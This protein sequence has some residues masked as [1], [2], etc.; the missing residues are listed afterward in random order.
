[1]TTPT[2]HSVRP[3]PG[4]P[5][6]AEVTRSHD[7]L[8]ITD[9]LTDGALAR[10]C[11]EL[12]NTYAC[13]IRLR[14]AR[15]RVIQPSP[16]AVGWSVVERDP[17]PVDLAFPIE[18]GG[19]SIG[20]LT[21][22][23]RAPDQ[24]AAP[25]DPVPVVELLARTASEFCEQELRVRNRA[26]ELGALERLTAMLVGVVDSDAVINTA[27]DSALDVLALDAGS[28]VVFRRDADGIACDESE[29][30]LV[31]RA[32][33]RLSDDW[34]ESPL[35]LS[36]DRLFDRLALQG[37]VVVSEDLLT[38][39][40]VLMPERVADEGL[41]SCIHA[42]L[43][44]AGRPIG[45]MRLYA[46]S[47][48]RFT[49]SDQRL[50]RALAEH[51][52]AAVERARLHRV[53]EREER[54]RQQLRVAGEIQRRTLPSTLPRLPGVELAARWVPTF[55]IGGDFY[56][57][58]TIDDRLALAVGDAVGKGIPAALLATN[59]RANLRAA[60]DHQR[61]PHAIMTRV[62][63]ALCRDT[64]P[65]EFVTAFLGLYDPASRT[66]R[67]TSAGH[68]PPILLRHGQPPEVIASPGDLVLGVLRDTDYH[69]VDFT[70]QPRDVLVIYSDGV[71]D[72][73]NFDGARFRRE[74]IIRALDELRS[75]SPDAPAEH[76]AKHLLW[77]LR[78][79]S[80]LAD[81]T[82]DQTLLV[83]RV[84]EHDD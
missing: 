63:A 72:T 29:E 35:P 30:D 38:D 8:S 78:R 60:A 12:S 37:Q 32:A 56:D 71:P 48:R 52:A 4:P 75:A 45:V 83:L 27:L 43:V 68:D 21:I 40:R 47:P 54:N 53:R 65:S 61:D 24:P 33:R 59:A 26:R 34:L 13:T 62:N 44:A 46:R 80:G 17:L 58:F 5:P 18:V 64:M 10:V 76:V 11:D 2:E 19:E 79:F 9:F 66:L 22:S 77:S 49:A 42:G 67:C 50:V 25:P 3:P 57:A 41:V 7:A 81:Q 84:T 16:E 6:A 82:D 74:G 39:P 70:L 55:E 14:D 23:P 73:T 31:L 69:T 36:R 28:V 1:M 15:R 20:E 51:A